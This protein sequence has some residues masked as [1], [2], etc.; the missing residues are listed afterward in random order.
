MEIK[1]NLTLDEIDIISAALN[2]DAL[3]YLDCAKEE[4]ETKEFFDDNM[5][6]YRERMILKRKFDR[7]YLENISRS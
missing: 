6:S 3:V 1:M 4:I 5:D 7:L 2:N